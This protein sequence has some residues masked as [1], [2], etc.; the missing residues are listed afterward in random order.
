[1]SILTNYLKLQKEA[2]ELHSK[3]KAYEES[4]EFQREK[5]FFDKLKGLMEEYKKTNGEVISTL[6][7]NTSDEKTSGRMRKKRKLKVYKNPNT[8][9]VV[10]TR[11]GNNKTLKSWKEQH[12]SNVVESWQVD[13]K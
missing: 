9:E 10:E 3:M 2:E 5:E 13:E 7:P 4:P 12:G 1:M 6:A 8:G 11:G